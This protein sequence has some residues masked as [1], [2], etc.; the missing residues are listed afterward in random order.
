MSKNKKVA[1]LIYPDFSSYEISILSAILR[2]F[3][4]EI[5]VFS[6]EKNSVDS[7]EGF[8]FLP[9]KT[10]NEFDI[11]DFE[12]LV[13]PGMWCYPKVLND[14]RYINFLKQFKNNDDILI[15][16]ISSSPVLLAK[17]GVLDNVKYC[18]G[19]FEEDIDKYNFLDRNYIVKAPIISDKNVITSL[20]LAYREFAIKVAHRLNLDCGNDWFSGIKKNQNTSDYIFFRTN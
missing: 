7:E 14:T 10:I 20:G 9:D 15:A 17:A 1:V 13:L 5:V 16:S 8:H 2:M 6:A 12:L 4:K 3:N 11:H 18:I 19:L